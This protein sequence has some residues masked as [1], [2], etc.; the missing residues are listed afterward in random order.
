MVIAG[1]IYRL[2]CSFSTSKAKCTD[3]SSKIVI[4]G[5]I[6]VS[7]SCMASSMIAWSLWRIHINAG[8]DMYSV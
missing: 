2:I 3:K 8:Y 5:V 6:G 4:S 7:L 1:G